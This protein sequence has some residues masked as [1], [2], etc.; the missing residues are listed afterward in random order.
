VVVVRAATRRAIHRRARIPQSLD[1]PDKIAVLPKLR[2][3][4]VRLGRDITKA[5]P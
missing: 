5:P 4:A 2:A 1:L 3:L